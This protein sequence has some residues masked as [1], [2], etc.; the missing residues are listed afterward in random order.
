MFVFIR[1]I[2]ISLLLLSSAQAQDDNENT[3]E[4]S[5]PIFIIE[6][7]SVKYTCAL[8]SKKWLAGILRKNRN[9]FF[10][11][12]QEIAKLN[13]KLKI[14]GTESKID[15]LTEKI[16]QLRIKRKSGNR[17]CKSGP[18]SNQTTPIP[19]ETTTPLPTPIYINTPV[20]TPI[21]IPTISPTAAPGKTPTF[22]EELFDSSGNVTEHGKTRLKIPVSLNANISK[23]KL[24]SEFNSCTGCHLERV[25]YDFNKLKTYVPYSPM[26]INLNDQEFADLT[27]YLNRLRV[28]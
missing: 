20:K 15:K 3:T 22:T 16:R 8:Q 7:S 6:I 10:S 5:E 27:A 18:P 13:Q 4:I 19:L 24:I 2:V 17:A 21:N 1:F 28:N 25:N 23:G 12:K 14:S 11:Y 26:Y 9:L